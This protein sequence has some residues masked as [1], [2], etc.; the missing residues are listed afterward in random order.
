MVLEKINQ[1]Y[2]IKNNYRKKNSLKQQ[3]NFLVSIEDFSY[4]FSDAANIDNKLKNILLLLEKDL[5]KKYKFNVIIARPKQLFTTA[6]VSIENGKETNF[7]REYGRYVGQTSTIEN[8][9]RTDTRGLTVR[10]VGNIYKL[11]LGKLWEEK[12]LDKSF[13]TLKKEFYEN[14]LFEGYEGN[15]IPRYKLSI[16]L[17]DELISIKEKIYTYFSKIETIFS[18]GN[19]YG[20]YSTEKELEKAINSEFEDQNLAFRI[21][22]VLL[23]FY[24]SKNDFG[25]DSSGLK[26]DTFIQERKS[27]KDGFTKEY[28]VIDLSFGKVKNAFI[29]KFDE[30]F[31]DK[32][33]KKYL[34][35]ADKGDKYIKMA[36]LI[37]LLS[38]GTYEME[39]GEYPQIFI[40]I[41]DPYKLNKII[42]SGIYSNSLVSDIE[43][44]YKRSNQL[45]DKFFT[46]MENDERWE[47]IENYFLGNI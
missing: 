24:C 23:K 2:T 35:Y 15:V 18:N 3:Q 14:T 47:F 44:R 13:P 6:F 46:Q 12:F 45:I 17:N 7:I 39:G 33:F 1:I 8:N 28:R 16:E 36:N 25:G 4:I 37:E 27:K 10:D 5:L 43:R 11:N 9:K 30:I 38:L 32:V 22:E 31:T 34:S 41:N 40:R 20:R 26:F 42:E 29:K 21:K 19:F